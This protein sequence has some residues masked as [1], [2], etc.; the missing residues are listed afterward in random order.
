MREILATILDWTKQ[1]YGD[2]TF[3]ALAVFAGVLLMLSDKKKYGKIIWPSLLLLFIIVNPIAY[4]LVF[5]KIRFWRLYWMLPTSLIIGLGFAE[6]LRKLDK[7]WKKLLVTA[8]MVFTV[9][10]TGHNV[11]KEV[12]LGKNTNAFRLSQGTVSVGQVMCEVDDTPKCIVGGDLVTSIRQY[13]GDIQPMYGRNALGYISSAS[14]MDKRIY[15]QMEKANP[16]YDMILRNAKRLGYDFVVNTVD[17]PISDEVASKYGYKLLKE[18]DGFNVYYNESLR[19][20]TD[21]DYKWG[22]NKYGSYCLGPNGKK[23]KATTAEIDG[24]WYYFNSKGYLIE[25]VTSD[26][27]ENLGPDDLIITQFGNDDYSLP[28]MGYT[29]D[30]QKGHFIVVDGGNPDEYKTITNQIRLYGNHVDAWII[31]HAHKDHVGAFNEIYDQ[32]VLNPDSKKKKIDVDKVITI[33]LDEDFFHEVARKWDDVDDFDKFNEL[34]KSAENTGTELEYV[35]LGSEYS[36][37]DIRFK[38]MNTFT[39]DYRDVKSGSVPNLAS[40]VIKLYGKT[41]SMLF[42]ADL[43]QNSAEVVMR[44]FGSELASD[45]V[46]AAHHGQNVDFDMYEIIGAKTVMVDASAWLRQQNLSTHTAYEHLEYF[47]GSG[48]NVMTFETAPNSIILK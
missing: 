5:V 24:S 31:T 29:I 7:E 17:R 23:L 33:D 48:M 9:I 11:F 14:K 30:D 19:D 47:Y 15:K 20:G 26:M 3:L 2:C 28:S 6:L 32:F 37:G 36:V 46:Q 18:I 35:Q 40:M 45:Y 13:S 38:V 8:L 10:L 42:L 25:S 44:N 12:G 27:A 21:P 41:E 4:K 39:D 22:E 34:M 43:E 1:Y 16:N